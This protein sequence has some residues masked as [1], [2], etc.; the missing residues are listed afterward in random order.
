MLDVSRAIYA[1]E[2]LPIRDRLTRR[3]V[4]FK[5]RPS[6]VQIAQAAAKQQARNRPVRLIVLKSRRV[7]GSSLTEGFGLLHCCAQP[8]ALVLVVAHLFRSSKGLFEVPINLI[9]YALP[10]RP[11]L[12]RWGIT[13]TKHEIYVPHKAGDSTMS[14]ATAG[15]VSGAG[16]RALSFTFLHLSEAAYFPGVQPFTSL[17]PTV[18]YDPSTWVV[19]ESTANG[20]VG[21]GA[22]FYDYWQNAASG[23]NDYEPVFLPWHADPTYIRPEEDAED[24]PAD[25]YERWLMTEFHCTKAQIAWWRATLETECKGIL[26]IMQQE[27]PASADE[28]FVAT[29]DPAFERDELDYVRSVV[30]DPEVVG[31]IRCAP[32]TY[33]NPFFERLGAGDWA[34]YKMPVAGHKYFMGVDAARGMQMEEGEFEPSPEGDFA[35][36]CIFDGNTGELVALMAKRVNPEVLGRMANAAGRFYNN[37]M[38]AIELTGNLGM[39]AQKVLRDDCHYSNLYRWRGSR[40]DRVSDQ[41]RFYKKNVIGWETTTRTREMMMDAYRAALR[42]RRCIPYSRA[43]LSQMDVATRKEGFRWEVVRGHDDILVACMVAWISREQWGPAIGST[44]HP[45]ASTSLSKDPVSNI[46]YQ[47]DAALELARHYHKIMRHNNGTKPHMSDN[48][49]KPQKFGPLDGI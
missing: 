4:P 17:L 39:W 6:Q 43:L 46:R 29:G 35:S 13:H 36:A 3:F 28:A 25:D 37:A 32:D 12:S 31:D 15:S 23:Y 2:R 41:N 38:V 24:A 44:V 19:I 30:C 7:G 18:P 22:A 47:D 5:L 20:R 40:D 11:T 42:E 33:T 21:P 9:D 49:S 8:A 48:P 10:N 27:Y 26:S 45:T 16:G 1:L 14:L 34:I